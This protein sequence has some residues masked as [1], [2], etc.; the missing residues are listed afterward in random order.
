ML[1]LIFGLLN[2]KR[3]IIYLSPFIILG[4]F[5]LN[6]SYSLN[7]KNIFKFTGI[8]L[9][10]I[11]GL[12]QISIFIPSLS[13]T[14]NYGMVFEGNRL[15]YIIKYAI[16]YLFSDYGSALQGNL[17]D[18]LYDQR[19][20]LGRIT[21]FINSWEYFLSQDL[22]H[23]FFGAG[24]GSYTSNEWLFSNQDRFFEETLFRGAFSGF[25]IILLEVGYIG[26][27]IHLAIF[28]NFYQSIKRN[29]VILQNPDL[30]RWSR[31][32]FIIF[33]IFVYDFFFYSMVLFRT[34]PM[35]LI[36][37]LIYFSLFYVRKLDKE[38]N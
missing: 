6:S 4:S 38:Y 17:Q 8:F 13:G 9:V 28:I 31:I 35:P 30:K 11:F 25:L 16:E 29:L 34:L 14:Q 10:F 1:A 32:V 22:L 27:A 3:S 24:F 7:F 15:S 5:L 20:Q 36:F 12:I 33:F 26:V 18:A 21:L 23:Q 2:E 37:I 19:V